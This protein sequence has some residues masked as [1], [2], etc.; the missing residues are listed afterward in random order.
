IKPKEIERLLETHEG[1]EKS[2][3]L[4]ISNKLVGEK[5]MALF[6]PNEGYEPTSEMITDHMESLVKEGKIDEIAIPDKIKM[7]KEMPKTGAGTIDRDELRKKY[8]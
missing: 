3:V 5:I 1:I 4:G 6:T 8:I 7:L 2:A